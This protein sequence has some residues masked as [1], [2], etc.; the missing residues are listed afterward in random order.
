[1]I[2]RAAAATSS[3][4]DTARFPRSWSTA[5]WGDKDAFVPMQYGIDAARRMPDG[6]FHAI[7]DAGHS[8]WLDQPAATAGAINEFLDR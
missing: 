1:M 4:V 6:E 3:R 5:A 8:V 2:V 7:T